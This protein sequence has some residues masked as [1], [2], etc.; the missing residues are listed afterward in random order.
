MPRQAAYVTRRQPSTAH[1]DDITIFTRKPATMILLR[2]HDFTPPLLPPRASTAG[3]DER[4]GGRD[5]RL[6]LRA[7]ATAVTLIFAARLARR[8]AARFDVS[9]R[10]RSFGAADG[11]ARCR[12]YYAHYHDN[13]P[14]ISRRRRY[15]GTGEAASPAD[16]DATAGDAGR[17]FLSCAPARR[18]RH[19]IL[20][21]H[22][23]SST[24]SNQG[25]RNFGAAPAISTRAYHTTRR[26]S[27][28]ISA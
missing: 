18:H 17:A 22:N 3:H 25:G 7:F 20:L 1:A 8:H 21:S 2:R 27:T 28:P 15:F 9:P 10:A 6:G 12:R 23:S 16:D 26:K 4:G 24:S 14:S 13:M 11:D 19:Y 5:C